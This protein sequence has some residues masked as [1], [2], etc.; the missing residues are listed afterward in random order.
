[1]APGQVTAMIPPA[2]M[3]KPPSPPPTTP[4][5]FHTDPPTTQKDSPG[6]ATIPPAMHLDTTSNNHPPTAIPAPNGSRP[7]STSSTSPLA[8][9]CPRPQGA[10]PS[11]PWSLNLQPALSSPTH[12]YHVSLNSTDQTT[13]M[14]EQWGL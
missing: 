2:K 9:Q 13:N 3:A 11:T 14:V 1:M 7:H 8:T 5:P 10:L 4:R 12:T 6:A